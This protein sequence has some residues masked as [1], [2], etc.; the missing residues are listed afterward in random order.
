MHDNQLTHR[1]LSDLCRGLSLLLHAGLDL[2]GSLYLLAEEDSGLCP[3][4]TELGRE[5]DNGMP[6]SRA[7]EATG[8]FPAFLTGLISVGENTGHLEESLLALADYCESR[9]RSAQ[10][11]RQ[12][13]ILPASLLL[14]MLAVI[15]VLLVKVLPVFDSV[16]AS[17]GGQLT[18]FS[19]LL[20]ALGKA[21]GR[22]APVLLILAA[23]AA[24]G[25]VATAS[26]APLRRRGTG[27]WRALRGD[28][29]SMRLFNNAHFA[30]AL[31]MALGSG[32]DAEEAA[33]LAAGLLAD[34]PGAAERCQACLRLLSGGKDLPHALSEAGFLSPSARRM[35]N[36]G[37]QS[38]KGESVME[39][40][41][42]DMMEQAEQNLADRIAKAEPAMVLTASALVGAIL[43]SVMLPLIHIMSAI[44]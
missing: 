18:G 41:A 20:L 31:A 26:L 13:L 16:Y 22:A 5:L 3:L 25:I 28:R 27:L 1:Q 17:M 44:G 21:L 12:A 29:G 2:A 34:T 7:M 33:A 36:L 4:L 32:L 40:I 37:L 23:L 39:H 30:R 43:L 8:R 10:M 6:L 38:G 11:L 24:A 35:L 14:L 9:E 42:A 15:A 19:A